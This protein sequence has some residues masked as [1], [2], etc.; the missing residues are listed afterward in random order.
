[1]S[2]SRFIPDLTLDS[3]SLLVGLINHDNG[4]DFKSG[5]IIIDEVQPNPDVD[6]ARNSKVTLHSRFYTDDIVSFWYNRLTTDLVLAA[7]LPLLISTEGETSFGEI[8]DV[9]NTIC[10][11]NWALEDIRNLPFSATARSS[12]MNINDASPAWQGTVPMILLTPTE[13]LIGV[14]DDDGI[15]CFNDGDIVTF[16]EEE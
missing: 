4:I 2:Q 11:T 16:N 6:H 10:G 15:L 3:K 9:V 1:M 12:V 8:L 7:Q 5:D 13:S 14:D